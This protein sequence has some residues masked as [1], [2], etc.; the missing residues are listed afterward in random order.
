M[1]MFV[2]T[3]GWPANVTALFTFGSVVLVGPCQNSSAL[4]TVPET[5]PTVIVPV[6]LPPLTPLML[7][8]PADTMSVFGTDNGAVSGGQTMLNVAD[9]A[10]FRVPDD[11]FRVYVPGLSIE[12]SSNV[13][14]PFAAFLVSVP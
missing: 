11:A 7:P 1:P 2:P 10:E 4:V 9:V 13:A 3:I 14:I 8:N 5:P 6:P 12:R